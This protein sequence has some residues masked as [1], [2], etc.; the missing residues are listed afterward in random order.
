MSDTSLVGKFLIAMPQM[1]DPNF[2]RRVLYMC[3][4]TEEG[5]LALVV[6]QPHSVTMDEIIEQLELDW[7]R[8]DKPKVHLGGPMS[9]ER[10]FILYEKH[11]ESEKIA[12]SMTMAPNLHMGTNPEIL[13]QLA[14]EDT[15]GKFLFVLGYAGW[16]PQQLEEEIRA[17]VWLVG[18]ANNRI[19]FDEPDEKRWEVAIRSMGIDPGQLVES[20]S[21]PAN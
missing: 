4:H 18:E 3:A 7:H 10:G 15:S 2:E 13:R 5:A 20:V 19:L 21:G 12:G 8:A 16:A 9:P 11:L 14:G 6:N 17:N 1:D